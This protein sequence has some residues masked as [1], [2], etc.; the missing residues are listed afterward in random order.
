MNA[1]CWRD[2]TPLTE[3]RYCSKC[4]RVVTTDLELEK[5]FVKR[6]GWSSERFWQDKLRYA[7]FEDDSRNFTQ[8]YVCDPCKYWMHHKLNYC[9]KCGGRLQYVKV[10]Y[11]QLVTIYRDYK[12]GY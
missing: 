7:P 5:E 1:Y 6:E 8:V 2:G 4:C 3:E 11:S 12:Q 9:T 10:S